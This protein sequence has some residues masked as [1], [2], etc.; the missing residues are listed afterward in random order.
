MKITNVNV[1]E[2]WNHG[3]IWSIRSFFLFGPD[4]EILDYQ[5]LDFLMAY[6]AL[7]WWR[8]ARVVKHWR[9]GVNDKVHSSSFVASAHVSWVYFWVVSLSVIKFTLS[10]SFHEIFSTSGLSN[11]FSIVIANSQT[12]MNDV[13]ISDWLSVFWSKGHG[14]W[15]VSFLVNDITNFFDQI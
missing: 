1:L 11:P 2:S 14:K 10:F 12:K 4:H 13:G 15:N 6:L 5:G 7:Q 3:I 9:F 8:V